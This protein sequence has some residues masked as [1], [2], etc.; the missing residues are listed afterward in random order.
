[1][2]FRSWQYIACH[3]VTSSLFFNRSAVSGPWWLSEHEQQG[4][5]GGGFSVYDPEVVG[6]NLG[7]IKLRMHSLSVS[8]ELEQKTSSPTSHE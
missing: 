8:V 3:G 7:W 1:M 4:G 5:G 6:L 2:T